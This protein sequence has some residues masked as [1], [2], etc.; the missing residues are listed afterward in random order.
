MGI[1]DTGGKTKSTASSRL[2]DQ[3]SRK[4]V[5]KQNIDAGRIV[6]DIVA[7][8]LGPCGRDILL[9][10]RDEHEQDDLTHY[11]VTNS[12]AFVLKRLSFEAPAAGVIARIAKAQ[13]ERCGDGTTTAALY[14]GQMFSEI[15]DLIDQGF[16]PTTVIA[17]INEA[18]GFAIEAIE[19]HSKPVTD[20]EAILDSIIR[21]TLSGRLADSLIDDLCVWIRTA[22]TAS[23]T[24]FSQESVQTESLRAGHIGQSELIP[25][26]VLKKSFAG[27]YDPPS[28]ESP[29]IGLATQGIA[30]KERIQQRLET[31]DE[32]TKKI[33]FQPS[34]PDEAHEFFEYERNL[35]R[36]QLA[37]VVDANIDVLIVSNRIEDDILSFFAAD[38][39]AVVRETDRKRLRKIAEATGATVNKYIE[40][41]SPD[42]VGYAEHIDQQGYDEIDQNVIFLR[43]CQNSHVASVLAHGSTWVSCWETERNINNAVAAVDGALKHRQVIPGGGAIEMEIARY[44]R[45]VAAGQGGRESLVIEAVA[46]AVEA[47]PSTLA[48]NAGMD[49]L[50]TILGLRN[51]HYHGGTETGVLAIEQTTGNVLARGVR[52]VAFTKSNAIQ[53]AGSV[54]ST[55]LRIDDVIS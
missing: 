18:V 9:W 28:I 6:G 50:E 21:T 49:P 29:R 15:D 42:D 11:E 31:G 53:A 48:R 26:F 12:G 39:I 52:E 35:L 36:K 13:D 55:I 14:A 24:T 54:V 27:N 2:R 44:L 45:D 8:T 3:S 17:G 4:N 40:G 51:S 23:E 19:N 43:D 30:R 38:N 16:H 46:D 22:V 20:D 1:N 10:Y 41:F 7:P 25:G 5:V 47:V 33:S 37:G 34:D 32:V